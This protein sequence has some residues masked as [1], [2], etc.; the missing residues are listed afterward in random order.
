MLM[1]NVGID[2]GTTNTVAAFDAGVFD[3]DQQGGPLLPSVVAFPPSGIRLI[4]TTARRRRPIDS[5]NTIISAKRLIGRK[6]YSAGTKEF[7]RRY[8]FDLVEAEDGEPSFKTRAGLFNPTDIATLI[9][10]RVCDYSSL[11]S[12]DLTGIIAV[13]AVFGE[14]ERRAT[15]E[16]GEQAGLAD[17]KIIDEPTAVT[18]AYL[19]KRGEGTGRAAVYD[20]GGG[21][22]DLAIVEHAGGKLQVLGFGGDLYLGGDDIDR[23]LA[24]WAAAEVLAMHHWDLRGDSTVFSRLVAECEQAKIRLSDENQTLIDLTRVDPASPTASIKLPVSRDL[25]EKL[26]SELVGRTFIVCDEVLRDAG[27]KTAD[28]DSLFVSGGTT[29]SPLISRQVEKYFGRSI[30]YAYHP[31]HIVAIG[32]SLAASLV[33]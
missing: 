5:K 22:F 16:A 1:R 17:V 21:T 14:A 20:F 10:Q 6:W 23:G 3:I 19:N 27:L 30:D 9:I 26:A 15:R 8:D 33:S 28:L 12:G 2:L 31:M 25:L 32:A 24:E 4:G 11:D 29:R 13:P 7:Q 18:L